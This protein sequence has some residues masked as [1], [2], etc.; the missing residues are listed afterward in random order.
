MENHLI[1]D[2][3]VMAYTAAAIQGMLSAEPCDIQL[4][5]KYLAERSQ[6][7]VKYVIAL[8]DGEEPTPEDELLFTTTVEEVPEANPP[9]EVP[10]PAIRGP[11]TAW[12]FVSPPVQTLDSLPQEDFQ[13]SGP[14]ELQSVWPL[15]A[16]LT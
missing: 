2:P 4:N 14:R 1:H 5:A 9:E 10:T 8:E 13:S 16:T 7:I 11:L 6:E 12:P 15:V 3:R